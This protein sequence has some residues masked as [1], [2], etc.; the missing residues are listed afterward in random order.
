MAVLNA[1]QVLHLLM[2]VA[3]KNSTQEKKK[4][5]EKTLPFLSQSLT[6][7]MNQLVL[8]KTVSLVTQIS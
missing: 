5:L 3:L 4:V 8:M 2:K 1:E 7:Q 6:T